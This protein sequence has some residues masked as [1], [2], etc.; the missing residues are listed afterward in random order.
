MSKATVTR[1]F[2]NDLC[3]EKLERLKLQYEAT[4]DI[5]F[6]EEKEKNKF[7]NKVTFGFIRLK[8]DEEIKEKMH[9]ASVESEIYWEISYYKNQKSYVNRL[10][11]LALIPSTG[12]V[13][14]DEDDALFLTGRKYLDSSN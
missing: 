11:N 3:N 10:K 7:W 4:F 12:L 1:Q 6:S 9:S 2:L 13:S 5:Y 14:L 8:S